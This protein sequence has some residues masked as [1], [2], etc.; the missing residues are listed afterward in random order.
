MSESEDRDIVASNSWD[1][2]LFREPSGELELS[3]VCGSVGLFEVTV[4]FDSA[5]LAREGMA[6]IERLVAEIQLEPERFLRVRKQ[7][8]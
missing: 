6:G 3:V 4:P 1:W 7:D 2:M 8:V 5:V